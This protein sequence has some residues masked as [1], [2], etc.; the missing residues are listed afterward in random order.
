MMLSASPGL[1]CQMPFHQ[2]SV[3][4][5]IRVPSAALVDCTRTFSQGK[6]GDTIILGDYHITAPTE[7]NQCDMRNTSCLFYE[8][9]G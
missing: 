4:V 7:V 3:N 9:F 1:L 2:Q 6:G 5:F 8:F